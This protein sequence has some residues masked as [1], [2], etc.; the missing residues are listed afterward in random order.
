MIR[1]SVSPDGK[2]TVAL[3][4]PSYTIANLRTYDQIT[5]LGHTED[6]TS[7][8]NRNNFPAGDVPVSGAK[9]IY[10]IPNAFPFRGTTFIDSE[11]AD[12]KAADP[13]T[14]T[15][16]P[17]GECS[18][19]EVLNK[20]LDTERQKAVMADLPIQLL[21]GLA[22]N[23]TDPEELVR[24]AQSCC[25]MEYT[26]AGEPCGLRFVRGGDGKHRPDVDDFELFE[27]IANNPFL[28]DPYKEVMVLRPGVQ[29]GSEIVGEWESGESHVFEYLR[30]NSYIPWGHFAA[31]MAH[32]AIRYRT[33]ELSLA[34][35]QGLRHLYY[36]RVYITLAEK[37]GIS[38][39]VR[40][41]RLSVAQLEKLRQEILAA[42][43]A[44]TEHLATLWGW[45]FGYDFS[46]SGY[47]LH[48]SHQ[49]IHQQYALVPETVP[50]IDEKEEIPAFS[51]GDLVAEVIDRYRSETGHDFFDDFLT[52][53]RS[54][55]RTDRQEGDQSLVVWEDENAVLFVPKAQVSQ[56]ELQL[57]L[58]ADSAGGP[59]GNVLEADTG[60]RQSMDRAIL[61]AQQIYAGQNARM[62]S[63]FEFSKRVGVR[64]G[65]RLIYS[66]LPKLPWS[67]GAFSEA[68]LR[69]ICGHY[70]EDF[71]ACCRLQL[72]K[73]NL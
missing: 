22:A 66:F 71:A 19:R 70:P 45:N 23:S 32:D 10:E 14:I 56:W 8:D 55:T 40:R 30:S 59:V 21:Y 3:H 31:N 7:C 13:A 6:G 49:M 50:T 63:S 35:M 53:L 2:F 9:P 18:L 73:K 33:S 54:N 58:K 72:N 11:W 61:L 17:A 52:A 5:V 65:Q 24:L 64:N 38:L 42:V 25:R 20:H 34:D 37:A 57:L 27:T 4:R 46:S 1:T 44:R 28:P 39:P 36:Q 43:N 48:A 47:R 29:G 67:M 51:S 41:T 26:Q 69:F 16:A 68:Q 12:R 60:T 15:L 62:V